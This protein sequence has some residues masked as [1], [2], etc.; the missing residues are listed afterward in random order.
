MEEASD[1]TTVL[2]FERDDY[3]YFLGSAKRAYEPDTLAEIADRKFFNEL[4][5]LLFVTRNRDP[6]FLLHLMC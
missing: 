6:L 5:S 1:L 3:S 4:R 2:A